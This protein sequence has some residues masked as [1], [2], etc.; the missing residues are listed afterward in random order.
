MQAPPPWYAVAEQLRREGQTIQQI[1]DMLA[2]SVTTVRSQLF[3]RM[4]DYDAFKQPTASNRA[5]ERSRRILEALKQGESVASVAKR[6]NVS[7]QWIYKLKKKRTN[8]LD[9][10]A[11]NEVKRV[12]FERKFESGEKLG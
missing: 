11:K 8:A 3:W 1:S 2:V 7:R 5:T 12:L 6:E 10:K 9:R 4:P